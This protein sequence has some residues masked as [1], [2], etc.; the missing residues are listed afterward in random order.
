MYASNRAFVCS[1]IVPLLLQLPFD[2]GICD[3][4]GSGDFTLCGDCGC[5]CD[6]VAVELIGAT[7]AG[8]CVGLLIACG[9]RDG[10]D[11]GSELVVRCPRPCV[12]LPDVEAFVIAIPPRDDDVVVIGAFSDEVDD[13]DVSNCCV[14][15]KSFE[16][17]IGNSE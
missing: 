15:D 11:V 4:N 6:L 12:L 7:A 14:S 3:V 9:I 10:R 17:K 16:S 2:V 1:L 5:E 13:D 8:E